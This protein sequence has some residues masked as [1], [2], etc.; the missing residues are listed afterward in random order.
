MD[1]AVGGQGLFRVGDAMVGEDADQAG[2]ADAEGVGGAGVVEGGVAVDR[3]F[4]VEAGGP[5][6]AEQEVAGL[7]IVV[8]EVRGDRFG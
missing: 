7:G 6:G 2:G 3:Q 1:G 4:P 8:Q 5:G